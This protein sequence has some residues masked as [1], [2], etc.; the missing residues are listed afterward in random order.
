MLDS[1]VSEEDLIRIPRL[2]SDCDP[3]ALE[4]SPSEGFLLSRID[5]Q[6]SW[7]LLREIGGLTSDE[8]D[9]CIEEWLYQGLID[10]EGRPPR[11]KRRKRLISDPP[12]KKKTQGPIDASLFE[13]DLDL[14]LGVQREILEYERK[15]DLDHFKLLGVEAS[16]D[17]RSIK[18]AYFALSKRF[19]PDRY[20]RKNLGHYADRLHRIFKAL[21]E[22]YEVLKDPTN[23]KEYEATL[24]ADFYVE[25]LDN[26]DVVTS[27]KASRQEPLSAAERLRHR[28][29]FRVPSALREDKNSK[30]DELFRAA[31]QSEKMGRLTE[32]ASN[33]RLAVAFDPFNREYKRVLGEVQ[34]KLALERIEEFLT[35]A[36]TGFST[37]EQSEARR[38]AE[39]ILLLRPDDAEMNNLA[40]RVY[41]ELEDAERAEEYCA[42]ALEL[43][44]ESGA[45]RRTRASV[46]VLCGNKGHA[47]SEL[48]KALELNSGDLEAQKMLQA[49]RIK[50]R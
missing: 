24:T 27:D 39:E 32:A 7:K 18:R 2:A 35:D 42:R 22:A 5:G 29:P 46:H 38:L 16:A 28:M 6:T 19:H 13:D 11:V 37:S 4:L 44:P 31:M 50:R 43:E 47:V 26:P 48:Q 33:M 15:I 20:F 10:V 49:L 41:V 1:D 45:F 30:G 14:D 23:R 40:A 12:E 9:L 25:A 3:T 34:A 8:V 36:K 21:S 17:A